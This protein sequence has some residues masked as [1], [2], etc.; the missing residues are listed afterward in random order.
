MSTTSSSTVTINTEESN[1]SILGRIDEEPIWSQNLMG[2]LSVSKFS[3]IQNLCKEEIDF[4]ESVV[5]K[6]LS[7]NEEGKY[8]HAVWFNIIYFYF[9]QS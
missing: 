3:E 5:K 9:S 1:S 2:D 6:Y 7:P 8:K 4:W